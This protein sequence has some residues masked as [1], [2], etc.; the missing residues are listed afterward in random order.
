M[1]MDI[2]NDF[3]VYVLWSNGHRKRYVGMTANL[4]G[5]FYSH[6]FL[7]SKGRTV[8]FR[9]WTVVHLEFY[10]TPKNTLEREKFLKTGRGREWMDKNI[11][12]E[13]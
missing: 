5:R 3:V 2:S 9:P 6:N 13:I 1:A 4:I 11:D 7:A 10:A 12:I 8:K